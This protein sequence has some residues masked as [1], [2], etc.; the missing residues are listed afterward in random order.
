MTTA[1]PRRT[2][3][4]DAV[5]YGV[6]I[7]AGVLLTIVGSCQILMGLA[8][9]MKEDIFVA[10]SEELYTIDVGAWGW[11]HM[12][13][14]AIGLGVGIGILK[15]QSWAASAGIG[16]AVVSILGEFAFMSYRPVGT[17]AIIAMDVLVIWALAR[18]IGPRP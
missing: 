10:G 1:P 12:L 13:L 4:E 6:A 17:I 15:G 5:A 9:V 18:L 14:G 2:H 16:L 11:A 3:E 8:A 7:F